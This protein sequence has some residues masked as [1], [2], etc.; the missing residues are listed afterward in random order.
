MSATTALAPS[1][2]NASALALPIPEAAPVTK[3]T[4]PSNCLVISPPPDSAL[5]IRPPDLRHGLRSPSSTGGRTPA[6]GGSR[7][8]RGG[9]GLVLLPP[10]V[11]QHPG[12]EHPG[13]RD[14]TPGLFWQ[15]P[16][17]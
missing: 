2:A 5:L 4:L 9:G 6:A 15:V 3:A 16:F 1:R 7:P 13:P 8:T 17:G 12:H 11:A 10:G 14:D